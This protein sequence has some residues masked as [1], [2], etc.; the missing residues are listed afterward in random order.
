[1]YFVRG[2]GKWLQSGNDFIF[3]AGKIYQNSEYIT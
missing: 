2:K 3:M 1:M